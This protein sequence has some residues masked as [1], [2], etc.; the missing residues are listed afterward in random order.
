[1]Y[2]AAGAT[3]SLSSRTTITS[4]RSERAPDHEVEVARRAVGKRA[5]E[6]GFPANVTGSNM[7]RRSTASPVPDKR[8]PWPESSTRVRSTPGNDE[9]GPSRSIS[10][11]L[12]RHAKAFRS[13]SGG[14][15]AIS[16]VRPPPFFHGILR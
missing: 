16:N 8:M 4:A 14:P 3:A 5:L 15:T 10:A 9:N 2:A 11:T 7:A 13:A 12:T 1:M 6:R